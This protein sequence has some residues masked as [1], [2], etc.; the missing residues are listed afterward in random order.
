MRLIEII[1]LSNAIYS[2]KDK[3]K[4]SIPEVRLA[5]MNN[6][7]AIMPYAESHEKKMKVVNET[8]TSD[9]IKDAEQAWSE[10]RAAYEQ[11][12]DVY[13]KEELLNKAQ[14][15]FARVQNL[16]APFSKEKV[17]ALEKINEEEIVLNLDKIKIEDFDKATKDLE[18]PMSVFMD[19]RFMFIS[20]SKDVKKEKN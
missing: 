8:Y 5:I 7:I 1:K 15:L 13:K 19:L 3:N 18:L 4:I 6:I 17:K 2:I 16:Q 20:N 14:E 10:S 11:E 9:E 12:K